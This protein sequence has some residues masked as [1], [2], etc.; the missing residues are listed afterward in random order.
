MKERTDNG[1]GL[2]QY[3]KIIRFMTRVRPQ[4][5]KVMPPVFG[6][7]TAGRWVFYARLTASAGRKYDYAGEKATA[8]SR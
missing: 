6:P 8:A 3:I 2:P 7:T 1:E 4:R 5:R